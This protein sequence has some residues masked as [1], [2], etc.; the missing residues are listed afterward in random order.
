M[1][2]NDN[3]KYHNVATMW[4]VLCE[5]TGDVLDILLGWVAI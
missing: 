3:Y 2:D 1:A 4:N 5:L